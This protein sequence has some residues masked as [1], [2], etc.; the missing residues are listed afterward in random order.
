MTSVGKN[1]LN[2]IKTCAP[3]KSNAGGDK[4]WMGG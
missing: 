4:V 1:V 2:P 3:G